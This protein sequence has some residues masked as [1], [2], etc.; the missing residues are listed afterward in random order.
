MKRGDTL[1]CLDGS[2]V[3]LSYFDDEIIIVE[4]KGKLYRR[5]RSAIGKTLL[6]QP[7][8]NEDDPQLT[9]DDGLDNPTQN[10]QSESRIVST[11]TKEL[12]DDC[13][14]NNGELFIGRVLYNKKGT[15]LTISELHEGSEGWMILLTPAING[16]REAKK[17]FCYQVGRDIFFSAKD[18]KLSPTQLR[19]R[20]NYLQYFLMW[21]RSSAKTRFSIEKVPIDDNYERKHFD[22]IES[23]LADMM[24]SIIQKYGDGIIE[25]ARYFGK[26]GENSFIQE[27]NYLK[28]QMDEPYFGRVDYEEEKGCYIGKQEIKGYVIEW[29]DERAALYYNYQLYVGNRAIGLSLVRSY[30]IKTAKYFGFHDLYQELPSDNKHDFGDGVNSSNSTTISD[31]HLL[32]LLELSR[33]QKTMHDI[34]RTI[35]ANQY[36]IITRSFYDHMMVKGCAGSG[37]TMIA[38]HRIRYILRN[39][40]AI[41]PE[42]IYIVSPTKALNSESDILA[43]TL[44]L[45][46]IHRLSSNELYKSL[47]SHYCRK[48]Q[49]Q[50]S[51]E[52]M[53]FELGEM[54]SILAEKEKTVYSAAFLDQIFSHISQIMK[55]NSNNKVYQEFVAIQSHTFVKE[56]YSYVRE[57][58]SDDPLKWLKEHEEMWRLSKFS[59]SLQTKLSTVSEAAAKSEIKRLE[60]VLVNKQSELEI[61]QKNLKENLKNIEKEMEK[62]RKSIEKSRK[63]LSEFQ[64]ELEAYQSHENRGVIG[65]LLKSKNKIYGE[66]YSEVIQKLQT[67]CREKENKLSKLNET[68][69]NIQESPN[70][71]L[72]EI[73]KL[74]AEFPSKKSIIERLLKLNKF[75]G[76]DNTTS[77]SDL[78]Y[79]FDEFM[80]LFPDRFLEVDEVSNFDPIEFM[81]KLHKLMEKM[82]LFDRFVEDG[83][84]LYFQEIAAFA[85]RV[86]KLSIGLNE[87]LHY[88]FELFTLLYMYFSHFGP[89]SEN[90]LFFFIDEFQDYSGTE[91]DLL[92]RI[93]PNGVFN[94]FGDFAQC[95]NSKGVSSTEMLP[96]WIQEISCE[97]IR[98][99]YRNALEITEYVN[100]AFGM[101]MLPIGIHGKTG[102]VK[103]I[104]DIPKADD[105]DRVAIIYKGC[106]TLNN[107]GIFQND[108]DL[109]Y[110]FWNTSDI[111]AATDKVNVLTVSLAKGLEFERV[112]VF[113]AGMTDQEQYV[114]CTR[115]LKELYIIK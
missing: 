61:C 17:Y 23:H 67:K 52:D 41:L 19:Q 10:E 69:Q 20:A 42:N 101:D 90:Q 35:Q 49:A 62:Q 53:T 18:A 54:D 111:V 14:S 22:F 98:E 64:E 16:A 57:F 102:T 30:D 11:K 4:Y 63:E 43:H 75:K 48:I 36:Q 99:N 27:E 88:Q 37:K 21:D 59:V 39:D 113:P 78:Y 66:E 15:S 74:R 29:T 85:I 86:A 71:L 65:R 89:L 3:I 100:T 87:E 50:F 68:Y 79:F 60:Q 25:K 45:D 46:Q 6:M 93:Y 108:K 13:T 109:K 112:I 91:L 51:F 115:A 81:V 2:T 55:G 72:A 7:L 94:Y 106:S 104:L 84:P 95:I 12:K 97:E 105:S 92:N 103:S 24:V 8:A 114:A 1:F 80:K 31:P 73:H 38:Y 47:I 5:P 76:R 26:R 40:R 33:N 58:S 28:E 34:I 96:K 32:Q 56:L 107:A 83:S 110:N 9:V 82:K 70:K 77:F 44:Q